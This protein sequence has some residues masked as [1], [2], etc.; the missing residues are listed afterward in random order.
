MLHKSRG[1][2]CGMLNKKGR[3]IV[4]FSKSDKFAF[5][6]VGVVAGIAVVLLFAGI[7]A[8]LNFVGM[9]G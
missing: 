3:A 6:V 4:E 8:V 9:V 2:K 7:V 1:L 5:L